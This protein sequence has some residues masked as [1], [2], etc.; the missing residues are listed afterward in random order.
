[1]AVLYDLGMVRQWFRAASG[2][3]IQLPLQQVGRLTCVVVIGPWSD[4]GIL[5]LVWFLSAL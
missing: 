4:G 2:V 5:H 3:A 1:M